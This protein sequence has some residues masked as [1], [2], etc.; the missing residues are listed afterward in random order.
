LNET[1]GTTAADAVGG[2]TGTD[3]GTNTLNVAED[4]FSGIA[5]TPAIAFTANK[6]LAV[7]Q[8]N[9]QSRIALSPGPIQITTPTS[10]TGSGAGVG[11]R[12][13]PGAAGTN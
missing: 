11:G 4:V 10:G 13:I 9:L 1:S 8:Q 2:N 3:Q 7:Q 12:T 5:G 6:F